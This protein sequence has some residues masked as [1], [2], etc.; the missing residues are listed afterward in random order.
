MYYYQE[1]P[2]SLNR[3][4]I[5]LNAENKYHLSHSTIPSCRQQLK[6]WPDQQGIIVEW[7]NAPVQYVMVCST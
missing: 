3:A 5:L 1:N 6:F 4:L 2:K 7:L